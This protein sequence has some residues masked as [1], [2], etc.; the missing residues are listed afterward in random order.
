MKMQSIKAK[1]V[2]LRSLNSPVIMH[3]ALSQAA[4]FFY[5]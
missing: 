2:V 3:D 1:S 5:Y 4:G